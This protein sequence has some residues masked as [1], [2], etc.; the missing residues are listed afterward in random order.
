[1]T[2]QQF[3]QWAESNGWER[4]TDGHLVKATGVG[5]ESAEYRFRL[6]INAVRYDA[7]S[8]EGWTRLRTWWLWELAPMVQNVRQG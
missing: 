3:I 6:G 8:P 4:G 5:E 1:M 7:K 2:K